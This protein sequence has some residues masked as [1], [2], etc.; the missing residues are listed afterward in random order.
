M[1]KLHELTDD[2]IRSALEALPTDH[3]SRQWYA[4]ALGSEHHPQRRANAR[5]IVC[6]AINTRKAGV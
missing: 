4:D 6:D 2:M 1:I 3:Y 5:R